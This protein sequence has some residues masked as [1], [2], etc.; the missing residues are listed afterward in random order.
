MCG[1]LCVL[2]GVAPTVQKNQLAHRGPDGFRETWFKKCYMAFNRLAINDVSSDGMQPF[3]DETAML[4]CNGEIYNHREIY[5]DNRELKNDCACLIP[6]IKNHGVFDTANMIRGVFA[7]CYYTET[8]FYAARDPFGVR[9]LFYTRDKKSG[10]VSALASEVKALGATASDEIH[11]FPPGHIYDSLIDKFVCYYPCYWSSSHKFTGTFGGGDSLVSKLTEAV[12]MRIA[13]SDRD[14]CFL[15]SG[16]LDSSLMVS[17]A[18]K[19]LGPDTHIKT[20]SIGTSDSPDCRAAKRVSAYLNTDHTEVR[21]DVQQGI[22][23]LR[24]VI[25]C[26][27]SYDTTT[28]RAS[29]PM[30]LLCKY[31]AENTNYRVVISGEGSDEIFG[32]YLYFH[33]APNTCAFVAENTRR[34]QLLH[35]FDVL[36]CDRCV[37]GHGLEARVPFLDRDFVDYAMGGGGDGLDQTLKTIDRVS[38]PIEKWVLRKAFEV[39]NYLPDDIL[40]RQK[41][42]FSDAVGYSWVSGLKKWTELIITE[43][44]FDTEVR[45]AQGH[46]VPLTKEEVMYRGIY[47]EMFAFP[48]LISE[49]WRPRWTDQ[50]DPSAKKLNIHSGSSK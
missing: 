31:I 5:T 7:F 32:G 28:V 16:G 1:I 10:A 2:G 40:W 8:V 23:S 45:M 13:N 50:T 30:W 29:I 34:L 37:S 35:Q 3:T 42:A 21:F 4:V 39:G 47:R 24:D 26:L 9:P 25:R 44:V 15:L 33:Y 43:S 19:L 41:D 22:D 48:K 11:I 36:R 14:V 49:I 18:R 20:F 38:R 6:L 27:E 17:I 12:R 46:N